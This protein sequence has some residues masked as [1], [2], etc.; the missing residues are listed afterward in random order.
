[1]NAK[2]MQHQRALITGAS[3]GIGEAFAHEFAQHQFDLVLVARSEP[4]LQTL[5][6]ELERLYGVEARVIA[7]DLTEPDAAQA[8]L[9]DCATLNIDVLVNNA[10]VMYHGSF[11]DQT[12][13][14]IDT[15]VQLNIASLTQL[16]HAFLAPM[17][18][19]G[20]GRIIN[21]TSTTGFQ[22][23]PTL[24]VY[25]ASKS[26]ILSFTEAL[27][28][29]LRDSGV[30]ATAFCPGSTD[31][32]MVARS[33]GE[34]LRANMSGSILMM[35]TA[36]VARQGYRACMAGDTISIPGLTNKLLN[37]FGRI[38]PRWMNRRVQAYMYEKFLD[39]DQG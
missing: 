11:A 24:A 28:E 35:S 20:R 23:A 22:G 16:T 1:M 25:A 39:E 4:R 19:Q 32:N 3:A 33:Y 13:G 17:L 27:A 29:E 30:T 10:G 37:T 9:E 15:I 2:P 6:V 31:T 8:L 38:Q 14:S 5:A 7:C 21:I 36:E 18:E 34:A 26:Y 12:T